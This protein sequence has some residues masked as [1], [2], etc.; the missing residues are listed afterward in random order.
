M[1]ATRADVEQFDWIRERN[2]VKRHKTAIIEEAEQ[3]GIAAHYKDLPV[4]A[5]TEVLADFLSAFMVGDHEERS[6]DLI[7]FEDWLVFCQW[8]K[9]TQSDLLVYLTAKIAVH[10]AN[11]VEV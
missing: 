6:E 2:A 11:L 9:D 4:E 8:E 10:Y 1:N 5:L 7:S 3:N